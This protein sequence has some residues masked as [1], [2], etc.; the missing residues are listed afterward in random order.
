MGNYALNMTEVPEI[1]F[2]S[3][4]K[5]QNRMECIGSSEY[6]KSIEI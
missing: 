4:I 3:G 1:F 5:Y 6:D 2:T